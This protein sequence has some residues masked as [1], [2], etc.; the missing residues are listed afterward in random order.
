MFNQGYHIEDIVCLTGLSLSSINKYITTADITSKP[1]LSK[2][3]KNH[4][5]KDIFE[6]YSKLNR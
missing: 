1:D 5:Y 2:F 3:M 4:P 6:N